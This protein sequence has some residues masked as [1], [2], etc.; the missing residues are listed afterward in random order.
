LLGDETICVV[1]VERLRA[2][3]L[4]CCE[5]RVGEDVVDP[6]CHLGL[7]CVVSPVA[8][9]R[10][11]DGLM[12]VAHNGDGGVD[13]GHSSI[14]GFGYVHRGAGEPAKRVLA[15]LRVIIDASSYFWM[16]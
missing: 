13:F 11:S 6:G 10:S 15:V 14:G 4:E 2:K 16:R 5:E 12:S 3:G 1:G 7:R 9:R 8:F